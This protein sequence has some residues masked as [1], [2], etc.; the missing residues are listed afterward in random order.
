M[1]LST[2]NSLIFFLTSIILK[3]YCMISEPSLIFLHSH[4]VFALQAYTTWFP[5]PISPCYFNDQPL[6]V[7]GQIERESA[8]S[9][10]VLNATQQVLKASLGM[11]T[12][13]L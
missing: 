7:M 4:N 2:W 6:S 13:E 3:P 12:L 8:C 11:I 1:F 10:V 5:I 9:P